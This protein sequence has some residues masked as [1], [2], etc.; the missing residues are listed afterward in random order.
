MMNANKSL[1]EL[2]KFLSQVTTKKDID[3]LAWLLEHPEC[4][5]R[6]VDIQTFIDSPDYLNAKTE[7]WDSIKDDL[8][9]LFKGNY[10]EAVFCCAIGSGKSFASSIIMAYMAYKLL[11]L[12]DPQGFFGLARDSQICFINMSLRAEQSKKV[13]FGEIKARIDNSPWYIKYCQII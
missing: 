12:K 10:T 6:I 7:C 13:V 4:E 8:E 9:E 3:D 11:C 2:E 5:H 1:P